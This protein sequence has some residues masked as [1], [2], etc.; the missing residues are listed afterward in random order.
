MD[1]DFFPF[2][3]TDNENDSP[4]FQRLNNIEWP[5]V[6][7]I[8]DMLGIALKGSQSPT[9]DQSI[10]F[11]KTLAPKIFSSDQSL[12]GQPKENILVKEYYQRA[13]AESILQGKEI[14]P[15]QIVDEEIAGLQPLLK[16]GEERNL[17]KRRIKM[18]EDLRVLLQPKSYT[19]NQLILRD[20]FKA[21]RE[22]PTPPIEGDTY[23]EYELQGGRGLRLRLLHPDPPEYAVGADLIYE[24]YWNKKQLARIVLVQYKI[25]DGKVLYLSQAPN[26]AAQL[27]KL[28]TTFCDAGLCDP[29]EGSAR[30]DAYRLPYCS[31]FLRPTDKLQNRDAH[32]IS[33][34]L[35]TPVCVA[36]R[37]LEDTTHG[38]KMLVRKR[39]RSE[40]LSHK[41]FEEAFNVNMLGSKWL[42]YSEIEDLYCT[43]KILESGERIK[44]HAQD[45]DLTA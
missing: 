22:I 6:Q 10:A 17:I 16:T 36:L 12:L 25:W 5:T 29:F 20:V 15:V 1:E 7:A 23:R 39:I 3:D 18:L 44:L 19:E 4:E 11:A 32:L 40:S 43:H 26:L 33:K 2:E 13:D 37:Q 38:N 34:G 8:R 45:F 31:A 21:K 14:S 27:R 9:Y 30:Q 35:Y 28:K 24:Q 42:T 41:V